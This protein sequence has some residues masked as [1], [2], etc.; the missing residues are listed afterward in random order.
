M[1]VFKELNP[2]SG[3]NFL[4]INVLKLV[5]EEKLNHQIKLR[6]VFE[7]IVPLNLL[8]LFCYISTKGWCYDRERNERDDVVSSKVK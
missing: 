8:Q 5:K 1:F 3:E 6:G 4:C 2:H 7:K